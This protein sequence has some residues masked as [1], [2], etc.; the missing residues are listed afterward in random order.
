MTKTEYRDIRPSPIAGQWYPGNPAY[1]ASSIDEMVDAA[2]PVDIP[3][4]IVALIV[5][6]AGYIYSG[7][8]AARAFRQVKGKHYDRVAI[9]SPMHHLY[10]EPVL[11]TAHD[12]Y[13]T[14]LGTIPVDRETL[15]ALTT[16]LPLAP[17]RRD[18]EHSLE[19][20]LPFL[21]RV[22]DGPFKLIPLMLRDQTFDTAHT[23]GEALGG[24][25]GNDDST[26]LVASSD[27]SHFYSDRQ[28]RQIDRIMVEQIGNNDPEGVIRVEDEKRAFACGRGAIATILVAA[29]KLGANRVEIIDYSTSAD[30]AG[31]THSVVGYVSAVL[32]KSSQDRKLS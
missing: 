25:L 17:I 28:A 29:G 4:D 12:A 8:T 19:I 10:R 6:H 22:L 16:Q 9:V 31:D 5:P 11:T 13:Q 2:A 1:L 3:G 24:L 20:E 14:P 32:Y 15:D 21:Q 26:L 23:L 30:T 18:P 27:L 7:P